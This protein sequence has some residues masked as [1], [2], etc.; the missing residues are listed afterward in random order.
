MSAIFKY[1]KLILWTIV[2]T[3]AW[4]IAVTIQ[5]SADVFWFTAA[6]ILASPLTIVLVGGMQTVLLWRHPRQRVVWLKLLMMQFILAVA[7]EGVIVLMSW[8]VS[9]NLV[10]LQQ[11]FNFGNKP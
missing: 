1:Q 11:Q 6:Q 5:G 8:L 10:N 9:S 4:T 3:I 2:T 7:L